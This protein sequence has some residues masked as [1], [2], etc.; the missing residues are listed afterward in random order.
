MLGVLIDIFS[1]EAPPVFQCK[2]TLKLKL[3]RLFN[4][5]NNGIVQLSSR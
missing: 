4:Y 2:L 3:V 1:D 5:F